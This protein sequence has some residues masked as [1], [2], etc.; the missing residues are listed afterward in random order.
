W[1]SALRY[2]TLLEMFVPMSGQQSHT[3]LVAEMDAFGG[4]NFANASQREFGKLFLPG[5]EQRNGIAGGDGKEQ[6]KIFAIGQCGEQ[7]R[8]GGRFRAGSELRAAADGNGTGENFRADM[9]G[10]QQVPQVA[11]QS[12]TEIDHGMNG[13]AAGQPA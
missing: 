7:R 9:A 8:F 12:V 2:S 10:F 1:P 13:K 11:G 5:I 3:L 6:F 4:D